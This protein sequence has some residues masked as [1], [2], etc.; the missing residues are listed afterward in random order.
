[1]PHPAIDK[2]S[3]GTMDQPS[4]VPVPI[5]QPPQS[6]TCI[7]I[8]IIEDELLDIYCSHIREF[9]EKRLKSIG[10]TLDIV[11]AGCAADARKHFSSVQQNLPFDLMFLD[12]TMP[13]ER[14]GN[15]QLD[16]GLKL[17]RLAQQERSAKHIVVLSGQLDDLSVRHIMRFLDVNAI[18]IEQKVDPEEYIGNVKI[19]KKH[20]QRVTKKIL[21]ETGRDQGVTHLAATGDLSSLLEEDFAL[22]SS[23]I[24]EQRTKDLALYAE[25]CVVDSFG[26]CFSR[27]LRDVERSGETIGNELLE[28][29]GLDL[30]L[31][32]GDRLVQQVLEINRSLKTGRHDWAE[33]QRSLGLTFDASP[34]RV[35][36]RGIL[37]G[38]L[39]ELD[40][41]I[42][43]KG[44]ILVASDLEDALR[45][46]F[47]NTAVISFGDEVRAVLSEMIL[48]AM[49]ECQD[50]QGAITLK[51]SISYTN[52]HGISNPDG[53]WVEVKLLDNLKLLPS[54]YVP[55]INEGAGVLVGE[56]FSRAW[57]LSVMQ[58]I[59]LQ[60]GGRLQ[61]ETLRGENTIM[62]RIPRARNA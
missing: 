51:P 33:L 7:R 15:P 62:Y 35:E 47:E 44:A 23:N 49:S 26:S 24:L 61:V 40:P 4:T 6:Q 43:C 25:R 37:Y 29:L 36:I 9:E 27:C 58:H 3:S 59:A 45:S 60:G 5:D 52:A 46:E 10:V 55:I 12:L 54:D 39:Q 34:E 56:R 18:E 53:D 16:I 2:Q 32:S 38:L 11:A 22:E 28:R 48:G 50:F 8:L 17:G 57:G 30:E 13:E 42:T 21:D 31:D 19:L 1:M 41:C 20:L 14:G